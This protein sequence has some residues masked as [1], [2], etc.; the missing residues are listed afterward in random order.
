MKMCVGCDADT[1]YDTLRDK[2]RKMDDMKYE[3][4][5]DR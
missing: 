4:K 2:N 3:M 5:R 1:N